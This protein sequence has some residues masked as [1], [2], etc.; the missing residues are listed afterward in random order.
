MSR[1]KSSNL[2]FLETIR[3]K[4]VVLAIFSADWS[5]PCIAQNPII[6]QL[7]KQFIRKAAIETVDV[8]KQREIAISFRITSIPT[9]ILFKNGEEIKRFVGLQEANVLSGAVE[10]VLG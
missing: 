6:D 5:T 1:L 10:E 8:D 9:L 2:K 3:Q 4:G 7:S